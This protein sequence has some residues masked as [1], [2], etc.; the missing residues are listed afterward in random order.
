MPHKRK[1]LK[2]EG[3]NLWYLVGL[4]ATDGSLSSDGRHINITSKNYK[5]LQGIK[6]LIGI[7]NK[8][9]IKY[10]GKKQKAFQINFANRNFY[11]LLLSIGLMPKKS[12]TLEQVKIPEIYFFE[13]LRGVIDG[14]G[15]IQRWI[16]RTNKREQWNLR[17]NSGSIKFLEWLQ[18][19]IE[20]VIG[21]KG[22]LYTEGQAQ[23]RLKYG[24]MAA[25]EIAKRCYYKNAPCLKRKAKLA[26]ECVNSYRGWKS[27]KTIFNE[28]KT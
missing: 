23:F 27:S 5:F 3:L 24:K 10:G 13:F 22:R 26:Q 1:D 2:I 17:I 19:K 25:R 6:K 14:D 12:L 20:R 7:G 21:A 11:D 16:H 28:S 15:G 4:I 8:I 9:G 18:N